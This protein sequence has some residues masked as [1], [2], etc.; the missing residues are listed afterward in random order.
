MPAPNAQADVASVY[1]F[2]MYDLAAQL[3]QRGL[4]GRLYAGYPARYVPDRVRHRLV[5]HPPVVALR[6]LVGR[7]V[8]TL[9]RSLNRA[10][11]AEFDAWVRRKRRREPAAVVTGLSSF[12]TTTLAEASARGEATICDRG[13]WHI[14]ETMEVLAAEAARW[15]LPPV[16]FDPWIIERELT[17]YDLV[18]RI[19]V[20]STTAL[21]S[22]IRRGHDPTRLTVIPYGV[23]L[24]A[25][26]PGPEAERDPLEVLCVGTVGLIKGQAYLTRAFARARRPGAKLT[27]VGPVE[28]GV[29]QA[30]ELGDDVELVGAV[31]RQEVARRMSRAGV[32]VLASVQEG[33]ALV[34]AQAMA[35]GLPVVATEA[36][37]ARDLVT[38][39]VEGYVV[40]DRDIGALT[41]ALDRLLADPEQALEM[42]SRARARACAL[43]GWDEY[44][45]SYATLVTELA[46]RSR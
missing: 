39:G 15:G 24:G 3:E 4:L 28:P 38:D 33:L 40:A 14:L 19:V 37:G 23:D 18:D 22:F 34:L 42:G 7:R 12:A 45:S 26:A 16:P 8:R 20:P 25:F 35:S 10:V 21:S 30:L 9:D 32:F 17:E 31:P 41:E 43:G 6:R 36:T 11:I 29:E 1:P 13:S 27:L 2:H 5:S 44:G 46:G